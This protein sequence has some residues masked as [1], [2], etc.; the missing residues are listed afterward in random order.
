MPDD[1]VAGLVVGRPAAVLLAHQHLAR[2]AEHDLLERVREVLV[3]DLLVLA[4]GGQQRRLVARGS[5]GRR[6]PC[7]A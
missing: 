5:P 4:A 1:R 6:R 3:P 2:R 7:R